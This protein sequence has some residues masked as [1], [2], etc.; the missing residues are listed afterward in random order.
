[1]VFCL[2]SLHTSYIHSN[3]ISD[4][5]REKTPQNCWTY[6]SVSCLVV[7][8]TKYNAWRMWKLRSQWCLG[9]FVCT[10]LKYSFVPNL[11]WKLV[12]L[13]RNILHAYH[14]TVAPLTKCIVVVPS[15]SVEPFSYD[16]NLL[17]AFRILKWR[18][19]NDPHSSSKTIVVEYI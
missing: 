14:G 5:E 2:N 12:Y 7:L 6:Q 4:L 16:G 18:E 17:F 1:M 11:V 13:M 9:S 10:L 15:I 19:V 3:L 8:L